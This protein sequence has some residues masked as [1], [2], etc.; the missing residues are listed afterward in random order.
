LAQYLS[1]HPSL[2]ASISRSHAQPLPVR[3]EQEAMADL[4][5]RAP[6]RCG[7]FPAT[8]SA[9]WG[10]SWS[11]GAPPLSAQQPQPVREPLPCWCR[12][13]TL[14]PVRRSPSPLSAARC[15]EFVLIVGAP[16]LPSLRRSR[17]GVCSSSLSPPLRLLG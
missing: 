3:C 12:P 5:R 4:A 14:L 16:P 2:R 1:P 15:R 7:P 13:A 11:A 9:R 8:P 6:P 17:L 10:S